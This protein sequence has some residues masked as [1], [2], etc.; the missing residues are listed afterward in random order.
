[1]DSKKAITLLIIFMIQCLSCG[2]YSFRGSIPS[3]IKK[4]AIP[5]FDDNT[6]YPGVRDDLS[7]G[8]IDAFIADNT[9]EVTNEA[10]ADLLITGT[11]LSIREKAAIISAGEEVEKY[12]VYVNVR[13]KCTELKISKVWYDKTLRRFGVMESQGD[14]DQRDAAIR[15]AI[16]EIIQDI[17][18]NTLANW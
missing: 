8:T 11:I 13:V 12:E 15:Q 7:N 3:N 4:I 10:N 1:M 9:L 5:M 14:Q 17:L 2:Y 6:S 16:K 18:D